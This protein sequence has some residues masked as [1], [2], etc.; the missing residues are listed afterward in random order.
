MGKFPLNKGS[1]SPSFLCNIHMAPI[2]GSS[3]FSQ[4]LPQNENANFTLEYLVDIMALTWPVENNYEDQ[5][6]WWFHHQTFF[7]SGFFEMYF[8]MSTWHFLCI[9]WRDLKG[10]IVKVIWWYA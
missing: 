1:L 5:W 10:T 8:N 9:Q 6:E 7:Q 4:T 2:N 3:D